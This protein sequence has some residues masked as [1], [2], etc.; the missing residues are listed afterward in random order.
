MEEEDTEGH[1]LIPE[2]ANQSGFVIVRSWEVR[3]Q[4]D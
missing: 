2:Q 3:A 1:G 4:G